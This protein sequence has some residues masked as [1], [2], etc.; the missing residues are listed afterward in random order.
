[1]TAHGTRPG[2]TTP[3]VEAI[4]RG[5]P[6]ANAVV[7]FRPLDDILDDGAPPPDSIADYGIPADAERDLVDLPASAPRPVLTISEWTDRDLPEPDFILGDWLTTTSRVLFAAATGLGK[8]NFAMQLGIHVAA[9]EGFLHWRGR[10]PCKVLYVDGEMSR[11]L[12]RQR[13]AD[14]VE[15]LGEAP[16]GF[17]VLSHEDIEGF[18]PLN[19]EAGQACIERIIT[20]IGGVDLI[21]FDSIM[22]FRVGDQKDGEPWAQVMPWVRSLTKRNVAQIWLHHTGHDASRSYGDK[23]REWQLDTVAHAEAVENPATDVSFK[24]E[25]RK[26]RERTP[27]TRSDFQT[28]TVL[29]IDNRWQSDTATPSSKGHVAPKARRFFDALNNALSEHG[30]ARNG[31][32]STTQDHWRAELERMGLIDRASKAHSARTDFARYRADL[33]S[34]N[35]I[36]CDAEF[37][38]V[39]K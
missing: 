5:V 17:H 38:W 13:I 27:T 35:F 24:L 12:L 10:R 23:S 11:R 32:P 36:A 8:T 18:P 2:F 21:V 39:V 26:A 29:L 6:A 14:A 4:W 7:P 28:T 19:T 9:G 15:R 33:V 31:R 20:E 1:M 16:I 22:C 25:F 34:A 30:H 3:T 37:V